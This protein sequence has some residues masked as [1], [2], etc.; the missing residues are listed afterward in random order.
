ME[1]A[2]KESGWFVGVDFQLRCPIWIWIL[3]PPEVVIGEVGYR[4]KKLVQGWVGTDEVGNVVRCKEGQ[5]DNK[6]GSGIKGCGLGE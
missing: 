4:L 3:D 1:E 6:E 5:G 2:G